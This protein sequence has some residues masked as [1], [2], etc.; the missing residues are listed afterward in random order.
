VVSLRII[1]GA[2]LT[3]S[4]RSDAIAAATADDE[5]NPRVTIYSTLPGANPI[6]PA[7][8]CLIA[9]YVARVRL[10][11]S[12]ASSSVNVMAVVDPSSFFAVI[13]VPL[14]ANSPR[15]DHTM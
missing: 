9:I 15:A 12:E 13:V 1:L 14:I 10:V 6:P 2:T 7:M 8:M 11:G 4:M 3:R 5:S